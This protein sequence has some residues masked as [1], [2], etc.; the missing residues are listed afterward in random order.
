MILDVAR[1]WNPIFSFHI[2]ERCKLGLLYFE[3]SD[4][5]FEIFNT[6]V[7]Q[8]AHKNKWSQILDVQWI[9]WNSTSLLFLMT[10]K[11]S[12][13]SFMKQRLTYF[14]LWALTFHSPV[15]FL[16]TWAF[17]GTRSYSICMNNV[18]ISQLQSKVI[19]FF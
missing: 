15:K 16:G 19:W 1:G 9:K 3:F 8:L 11:P 13:H 2:V 7:Y 6:V 5:Y 18:Y 4:S 14:S 12:G 10:L 17:G